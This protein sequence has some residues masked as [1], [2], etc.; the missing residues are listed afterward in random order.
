MLSN[1]P[2]Y[3]SP[4]P[5]SS[6]EARRGIHPRRRQGLAGRFRPELG[7][8]APQGADAMREGVTVVLDNLVKL[9]GKSGGFFVCQVKVH[10]PDMG[11]RLSG[12]KGAE[13]LA[14]EEM[15]AML[16]HGPQQ[17]GRD[18]GGR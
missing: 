16:A 5:A 15:R 2:P 3:I 10:S 7:E 1:T 14:T 4:A 12:S 11:S 17:G 9:L 13:P 18:A 8:Y 6:D